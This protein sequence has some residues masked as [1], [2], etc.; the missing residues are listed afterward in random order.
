M[1][2]I[3][4]IPTISDNYQYDLAAFLNYHGKFGREIIQ[5]Y[6]EY[7]IF[8]DGY[9]LA[10][11]YDVVDTPDYFSDAETLFSSKGQNGWQFVTLFNSSAV[12]KKFSSYLALT[13]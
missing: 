8:R 2:V 9:A 13:P 4:K 3:Y 5:I 7:G 6:N 11:E 1:T 12:F 10:L